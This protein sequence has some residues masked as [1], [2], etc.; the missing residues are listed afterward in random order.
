MRAYQIKVNGK[1]F[2]LPFTHQ[3]DCITLLSKVSLED[4]QTILIEA[5]EIQV[6]D[7]YRAGNVVYKKDE[8]LKGVVNGCY[9]SDHAEHI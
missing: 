4:V 1:P 9:Y 6:G 8:M 7:S 2:S 5:V 3:Q